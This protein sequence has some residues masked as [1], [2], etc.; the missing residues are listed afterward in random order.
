MNETIQVMLGHRSIRKFKDAPV[1]KEQLDVI[2]EAAQHAST[3]SN[4][5]AFTVIR[6]T[7]AGLRE[8]LAV[9]AGNQAYVSQC[10]EFLVWCADLHRYERAGARA[11]PE[12]EE[13][14]STTENFIVATVDAALAAQNAAVAAESLGLGIVYIGGLRNNPRQVSELLR[15]PQYVYPV[16][17]M[18]IGVPDQEPLVRPRLPREAILHENG[19]CEERI[20]PAIDQYNVTLSDYM[21][22]RTNGKAATSWSQAMAAKKDAPRLH[23]REFLYGQGFRLE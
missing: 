15:L 6:I 20:D 17:G 10:P 13:P 1:A 3:S 5:Q 16:F 4:M 11:L 12:G 19:Y 9:L 23:M 8:Q 2:I 22:E 7:D 21:S 18:C 14:R